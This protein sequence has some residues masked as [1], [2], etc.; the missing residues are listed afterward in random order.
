M[1][2]VALMTAAGVVSGYAQ[3]TRLQVHVPF[4]FSVKNS[5]LPAGDYQLGQLSP[6]TWVIRNSEG[7]PAVIALARPDRSDGK[8]AEDSASVAFERCGDRYFL[9]GLQVG[10]QTSA[11][12]ETEAERAL[13]REMARGGLKP[14]TIYVLASVR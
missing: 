3:D 12:P 5:A 6:S 1:A 13:Q 11:I 8:L 7:R 10:T 14:E 2:G 9:S 4:A